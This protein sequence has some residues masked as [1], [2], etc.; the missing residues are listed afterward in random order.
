[1]TTISLTGSC[2]CGAVRYAIRGE[3]KRFYHCHCSRCRKASGTGHAS[4]MMVAP[5]VLTW[6]AGEELVVRYKLPESERF[7]TCFCR[8]CGAPLPRE[9]EEI[10]MVVIP[11]GSLDCEVPMQPQAHIFYGSR[12]PWS[13]SGDALPVFEDVPPPA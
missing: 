13:C 2:L 7:R 12:T 1:M 8:H 5:E 10:G 11:A 4:N 9:V 3:P 6:T